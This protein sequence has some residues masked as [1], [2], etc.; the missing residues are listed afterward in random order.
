[1]LPALLDNQQI[2]EFLHSGCDITRDLVAE[3]VT[4]YRYARRRTAALER[5]LAFVRR[6]VER[7]YS[8]T[9]FHYRFYAHADTPATMRR[10]RCTHTTPTW[11]ER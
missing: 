1:M 11:R 3:I 2:D 5:Y 10:S 7:K 8:S 4:C 6:E 9:P